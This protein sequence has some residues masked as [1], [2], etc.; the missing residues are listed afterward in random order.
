MFFDGKVLIFAYKIN[1]QI[2]LG[3]I[4]NIFLS[5]KQKLFLKTIKTRSKTPKRQTEYFFIQH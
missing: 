1:S 4:S 5:L 2:Q 3:Q